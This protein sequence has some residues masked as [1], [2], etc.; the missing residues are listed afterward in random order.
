M[1]G[2]NAVGTYERMVEGVRGV[3]EKNVMGVIMGGEDWMR[4]GKVG[5]LDKR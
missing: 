5:G 3:V 4:L 1:I 2:G